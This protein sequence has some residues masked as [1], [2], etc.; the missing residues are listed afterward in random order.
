[1]AKRKIQDVER[2]LLEA[3]CKLRHVQEFG[4]EAIG[5][6]DLSMGYDADFYLNKCPLLANHVVYYQRELQKMQGDEFGILASFAK[7]HLNFGKQN[8]QLSLF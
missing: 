7:S 1:M 5:K 8:H 6:Y 4:D 2:D 3:K